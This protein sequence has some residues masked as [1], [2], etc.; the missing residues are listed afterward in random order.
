MKKLLSVLL[1][2][3]LMGSVFSCSSIDTRTEKGTATGSVVGAV[4]GAALGQAIGRDTESTLWGAAIGGVVGG[5]AGNRI[6]YYMDRQ[7]ARL[8]EIAAES[9]SQAMSTSRNRDVLT[10]TFK[11]DVLFAHDSSAMKPGAF[12]EISRVA[13]ML[14]DFPETVIRVD[15]HTDSTGSEEYNQRLSERRAEAVKRALIQRNVHS[16]RIEAIGYGETMPV[17]SVNALNRRV[18][19]QIVPVAS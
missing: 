9:R 8:Q 18:E 5:I 1:A 3:A 6:G 10:A 7:E 19:I 15:G 11:S 13:N 12:V 14:N 16:E 4:A 2:A 17:S